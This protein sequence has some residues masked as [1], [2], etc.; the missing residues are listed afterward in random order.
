MTKQQAYNEIQELREELNTYNYNYYV[1]NNPTISDYD[2]DQKL[3]ELEKLEIEYP[4]FFDENSPTQRVGSDINKEF[5]QVE[6]DYLMLSLGNTYNRQE[7][8]DFDNRIKKLL[9]DSYEYV[10]ELKFDGTAIA[11]RY[12]NGQFKMAV[13]RGDGTRGD[14]VSA[15][16]RTIKSI[17]LRLIGNKFPD[18]FEI[19]GEVVFPHASFNRINSERE[20]NGELPF[21]N[22]RNAASG[23]LKMQNS[24]EVAQRALDSYLYYLL[25][26]KLPSDS[27]YQNMQIAKSW[28]FKISE[29]AKKM[30][31]IQE[32]FEYI[33]FWDNERHNLPYD[34]DGIVIKVDSL[35]QQDMLGFTS[36]TPR[37]AI[38]YKFK[39]E[40]ALSQLL[41][42]DFQVGRT[43]AITPVANLEPVQL[44]GT[45]VKR[46]SL[47]NA[48]IIEQLDVNVGDYVY[49]EKGGEIIPK[50]VGVDKTQRLQNHKPFTFIANCPA[51]GTPLIR[52][53][54]EA[55][56]YCPNEKV[57]PPQIKGKIEHFI[58]RKAMNINAAEATVEQLF[59]QNLVKNIADL[60]DLTF[61]QV[62][63]LER[64]AKKSAENLIQS[65]EESKNVSFDRVLY[66]LGIRFV[67]QTV[68]KILAKHFGHIDKIISA[69][70]DELVEIDEIG[71]RIALSLIDFFKDEDKLQMINRM[72]EAGVTFEMEKME[73]NN[74]QLLADKNIVISGVFEKYSR[75]E[76]KKMI[77]D[78][79][80]KNVSSISKKTSFL[81]AGDKIGP[82]KL[83]KV[84]KLDIP[85]VSEDEFLQMIKK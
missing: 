40:Q 19:R 65:I 36:K 1:L 13:T 54:G 23:T 12:E 79:G 59:E 35:K 27:H 15:N 10:A 22:P 6:H 8:I 80:G 37:W 72:K 39:A 73:N 24:A 25:A 5:V 9:E 67:G 69:T 29:H 42:I 3:K 60:Y 85:M 7:L 56:H 48:D 84:K 28:G 50:I 81:L 53:E 83:E 16:A 45:T 52:R 44:A 49:V 68:A 77:E 63:N 38:S 64:F 4:Q 32:V 31:N 18:K 43:G 17:P 62:F 14:D 41:S 20:E 57:C 58:S 33:D 61:E 78:Y 51:C 74:E 76:L 30:Q 34:I 26:P 66:S 46:A 71:E 55:Q 82:S 47:H 75:N 21:A 11:L 2:F 70:Y